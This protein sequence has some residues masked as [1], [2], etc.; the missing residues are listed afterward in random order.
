M[1]TTRRIQTLDGLPVYDATEPLLIEVIK[2]DIKQK[3][4][5]DPEHCAVAE[6]CKRELHA[7]EARAYLSRLYIRM[8]GQDHWLRYML[9][10]TIRQEVASFDRG[11]GFSVGTYRIP[12][13]TPSARSGAVNQGGSGK[14]NYNNPNP[15]KPPIQRA[16][17][18]VHGLRS[19]SPLMG[20]A[21]ETLTNLRK[22]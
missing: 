14:H 20:G 16:H 18:V 19:A 11:G 13:L 2:A 4:R 21:L 1:A 8:P 3:S 15:T 17:R 6:A 9:P 5:R 22:K 7:I 12:P 10:E